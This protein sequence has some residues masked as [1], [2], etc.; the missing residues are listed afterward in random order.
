MNTLKCGGAARF[1]MFLRL[2]RENIGG[3]G[4][5]IGR[6]WA[7]AYIDSKEREAH[8]GAAVRGLR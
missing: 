7:R 8:P 1:V 4:A 6:D 2:D 3:H 5:R